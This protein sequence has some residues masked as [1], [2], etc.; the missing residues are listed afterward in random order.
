MSPSQEPTTS[1][2]VPVAIVTDSTPYL[3]QRLIERRRIE[4]VSLYVG[5]EGD[6]RREDSYADLDE[7]YLRLHDSANLPTTSQPSAGDFVACYEPLV[8]AGRDVLSLHLAG[9]LSGTCESAREAARLLGEAGHDGRVEVLDS[10]TGAGG[11]GCLVLLAAERAE[12]GAAL[13]EIVAA[14][15]QARESLDI[16][17]CLDTLEYLR[18]GGRIGA[19]Q[20][21]V[22]TALKL[23][24]ILT[25]GTEIA[26]VGR[27]RTRQRA[28]ERMVAYLGEL[29]DRGASD[30]IVQ[31]AQAPEDARRL[32]ERGREI[33][34]FEELFCTQVG[35]VLGAHLGAGMLVGGMTRPPR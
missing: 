33:F 15:R 34:G 27:V 2:R 13:E 4:Q 28:F 17:F 23:K 11:L 25:F 8:R 16:W 21:V 22:G 19:A 5:W 18:R 7:F 30:W 9:G 6:L 29:H 26:P 12:D 10:Q 14:V 31:H 20:A 3:P 32:V 24:P 35:P 1:A